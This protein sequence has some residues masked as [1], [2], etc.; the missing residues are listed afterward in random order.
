MD[1]KLP[2]SRHVVCLIQKRYMID[3]FIVKVLMRAKKI[4]VSDPE[5]KTVRG[6]FVIIKTAFDTIGFFEGA[7]QPFY[8]LFVWTMFS[9]NL[10]IIGQT[11][12]LGDV[13]FKF[14]PVFMK[15]LLGSKGIGTVS[16]CDEF[17]VL[18]KTGFKISEGHPHGQDAG[19]DRPVI[20]YLVTKD[21]TFGRIQDKPDIAFD[22]AYFDIGLIG[23]QDGR[24][25]IIIVVGKRFNYNGRR[26][27]VVGDLLVGEGDAI[28]FFQSPGCLPKRKP[29]IDVKGKADPHDMRVKLFKLQGR[30]I[31]REGVKIH[32]KEIHGKFPIDIVKFIS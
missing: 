6:T 8:D 27:C 22:A 24:R 17:K 2:F 12:D 1:Q 15:K 32:A 29:E 4:V 16:V 14:F 7:V 31:L 3:R 19:A 20:G 5:C 30:R 13:K 25:L 9:G 26:F 10:I 23:S 21:G 11:D 28:Q 18:W